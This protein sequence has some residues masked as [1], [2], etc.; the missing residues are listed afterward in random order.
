MGT[1]LDA[2]ALIALLRDEPAADAVE[3]LIA[4]GDAAMSTVNLAEV[5][6]TVVREGAM[7]SADLE[8]IVGTLPLA[9][10]PFTAAHAYR[11]AELRARHYGRRDSAVSLADCCL[12][13]VATP[14]DRV[15]TADP[16]VLRMAEAEGIGTV[17]LPPP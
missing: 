10:V 12:V 17:A 11:T 14:A 16:V 4:A 9:I 2:F 15:A 5:G 6:Q 13:A 1:V 3:A 8:H 7:L